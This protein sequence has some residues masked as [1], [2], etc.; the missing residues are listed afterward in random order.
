[1]R[2]VAI[3]LYGIIKIYTKYLNRYVDNII[4]ISQEVGMASTKKGRPGRGYETV[5]V[6]VRFPVPMLERIAAYHAQLAS[7]DWRLTSRHDVILLLCER[8]LQAVEQGPAPFTPPAA[9]GT[10]AP[11]LGEP[12][13][14]PSPQGK[15]RK[16]ALPRQLLER[17]AAE[18]RQH[19]DLP[20]RALSEHLFTRGI[21]RGQSK[22]GAAQP[23]STGALWR[24]LKEAETAGLL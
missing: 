3:T 14:I 15:R 21:Y 10:G 5:S 6:L 8:G 12:Q 9:G 18:R 24:W 20:L 23:P 13:R 1:M 16:D 17:I 2:Q 7:Q 11:G 22:R 4:N 19:P